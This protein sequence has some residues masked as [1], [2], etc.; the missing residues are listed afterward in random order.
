[1]QMTWWSPASS[2]MIDTREFCWH[3]NVDYLA[4]PCMQ[5][6]VLKTTGIMPDTH[7]SWTFIPWHALIGGAFVPFLTWCSLRHCVH[8]HWF[9]YV[10]MGFSVRSWFCVLFFAYVM[11]IYN[12][13][14]MLF[15]ERSCHIRVVNGG[16][17]MFE[18]K[19]QSQHRLIFYPGS[20]SDTEVR[21]GK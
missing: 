20:T 3:L 19:I 10:L 17:R 11:L 9:W 15:H 4:V 8:H 2:E 21:C 5:V 7:L 6:Y 16:L 13:K 14:K 12:M 1:M 18:G